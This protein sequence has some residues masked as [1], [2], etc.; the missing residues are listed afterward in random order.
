MI[1]YFLIFTLFLNCLAFSQ[2]SGS[3]ILSFNP[4]DYKLTKKEESDPA[5]LVTALI[6]GKTIDQEKFDVIYAWVA[7]NIRY[8][9]RQYYSPSGTFAQRTSHILKTKRAVCLGYANLMDSLLTI[10]G[11]TNTTVSGYAKDEIFDVHDSIYLDNHAWNA[12]K[13]D[14]LWYLYDVTWSTGHLEYKYTPFSKLLLRLL[15]K[16]QK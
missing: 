11:I 10:A 9:F 5:L 12:V 2:T 16:H 7:T 3:D 15:E 13:L 8:D 6:K 1:K 4:K 14:G